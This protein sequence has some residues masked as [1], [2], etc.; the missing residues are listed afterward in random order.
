MFIYQHVLYHLCTLIKN[1]SRYSQWHFFNPKHNFYDAGNITIM[2]VNGMTQKKWIVWVSS[3]A[4][5][6]V[7]FLSDN[8][9]DD[10]SQDERLSKKFISHHTSC[11]CFLFLSVLG[12]N[13]ACNKCI[14]KKS[15]LP[16]SEKNTYSLLACDEV[17]TSGTR[18]V[19]LDELFLLKQQLTGSVRRGKNKGFSQ[20]QA[21][22]M[23]T[24]SVSHFTNDRRLQM[25]DQF[26][27]C[28]LA[29]RLQVWCLFLI[30]KVHQIE[31]GD[32]RSRLANSSIHGER[33]PRWFQWCK[34]RG[35]LCFCYHRRLGV[36]LFC[37]VC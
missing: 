36:C 29:H 18:S 5:R 8:S 31:E 25:G 19:M 7:S 13:N 21:V 20:K 28:M 4:F 10:C 6:N 27:S 2:S 26:G 35:P 37:S 15:S 22:L 17:W 23:Q 3:L 32:S 30:I 16:H 34:F 1:L 33:G 12:D 24:A 11:Y 14:N 9:N